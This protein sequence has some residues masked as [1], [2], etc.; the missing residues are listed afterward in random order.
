M[1]QEAPREVGRRVHEERHHVDL[2]VPE[3]VALV[4][5]AGEALG[6]D[7]EPFRARRRLQQ[8]VQAEAHRLLQQG[9]ALGAHVGGRPERVDTMALVDEDRVEP[10]RAGAIQRATDPEAQ[11]VDRLVGRVMVGEVLDEAYGAARLRLHP[12]DGSGGV[13]VHLRLRLKVLA[14]VRLVVHAARHALAARAR[15]ESQDDPRAGGPP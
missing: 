14:E 13:A 6:G 2:G 12:V 4:S 9:R 8:L 11:L 1:V 5:L 3:V 15:L 7:P 10:L